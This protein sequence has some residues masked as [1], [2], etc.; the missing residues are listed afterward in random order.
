MDVKGK[1]S[2]RKFVST[3]MSA[4]AISVLPGAPKLLSGFAGAL[5]GRQQ[6]SVPLTAT[7]AWRDQGILNLAKSPY[8]MLHSVPVHAVTIEAG[9]WSPRRETNVTSSI[10][11]MGKLLEVNGRMD[12]FRR[13]T[14]KSA[15]TQ[16][17]PVYAD[18][19]IYKWIEAAGFA[20]QAGERPELR[21]VVD[22]DIREIVA[23]QQADGYLNTYYVQEHAAQR[24][25]PK[26]QQHGHELYNIGHLLQ[27][28]I[29]YY[30]ATGDR[31]LLDAGIRFVNE[32]LLPSFG[33]GADKK[34]LFSGHPEM[35][36]ALV[37][38]YRLTGD[39]RHLELA[40]YLLAGD[41][42]IHF[43]PEN[44]VYHFCGIPFTSRTHLEGHAVRA[45]YACCGA[46]DYY[47]ETGDQT[48]WKTL[49]V[50][51]DG[52]WGELRGHRQ[53]DVE[54][55]HAGGHRRGE[56]RRRHR[57]CAVQRDQFGDVA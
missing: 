45:M 6:N 14:G 28:A 5:G 24:M 36:L 29:A 37:E 4:S 2:R 11:S 40:G 27:G 20:L 44:Y 22:K 34:P 21:A 47:L 10:P 1:Y 26:T 50:L 49:N 43:K 52:V 23:A 42:R 7:P 38:L 8:A 15:G 12:N 35:E 19:D 17:G 48:Y 31:T 3:A 25:E 46:T 53:H 55:A 51:R 30:R 57:T 56:V 39:K 13:L 18:S 16:R 32:F 41:P 54:L 9:F 33:P